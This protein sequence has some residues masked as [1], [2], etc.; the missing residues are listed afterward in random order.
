MS[1]INKGQYRRISILRAG[2][3][4]VPADS[5]EEAI[6]YAAKNLSE[7]DFDWERVDNDLILNT[8]EVMETCGPF[9]ECL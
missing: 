4:V 8:A 3:A 6:A 2:Y 1:E 7:S 5:D 9:G